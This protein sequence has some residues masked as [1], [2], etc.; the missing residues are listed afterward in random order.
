MQNYNLIHAVDDISNEDNLEGSG[1]LK[2]DFFPVVT[3]GIT[4][5]TIPDL[6][7]ANIVGLWREDAPWDVTTGSLAD[8]LYHF[9]DTTGD[10]EFFTNLN[11]DEKIFVIWYTGSAPIT[12]DEPVTVPEMK[13]YMRLEGFTG[14]DGSL[15]EFDY[16]DTI[17][18]EMITAAR[19][20]I[21]KYCGISIVTKILR[22]VITNCAGLQEIPQGPVNAI[23]TWVG[24]DGKDLMG[25]YK[26]LGRQFPTIKTPNSAEMVIEYIA[27]YTSVPKTLKIA[28]MKQV[29]WDYE[30]RGNES[31][32]DICPDA[33]YRSRNFNRQSWLA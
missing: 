4:T 20:T 26:I 2:S 30:H 1:V 7:D 29:C 15:S 9:D 17:I 5:I 31:K 33:V 25:T 28:I 21:E 10:F 23:S 3:A 8:K 6:I 13:S 24:K 22:A 14:S 18:E 16:D 19:E 27:G 12:Y 32:E 11:T